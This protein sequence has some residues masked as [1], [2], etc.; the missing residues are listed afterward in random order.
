MTRI[1]VFSDMHGNFPALEAALDHARSLS[2]D[3]IVHAG[4]M[5][6]GPA[7]AEVLDFLA[8][9]DLP[10]V[11]GNHE[12][13][14]LQCTDPA[15]PDTLRSD[16]YAPVR[17]TRTTLTEAHLAEIAS[18]P[19]TMNPHPD[20][21]ILHGSTESLRARLAVETT[22]DELLRMYRS[23]RTPVIVSGHT[24]M[25]HLRRLNGT[26]FVNAG[27]TGRPVDGDR[28]GAYALLTHRNGTWE[29]EIVRV[30]YDTQPLLDAARKPGGWLECGGGLAAIMLH[31]MLDG[32]RWGKP[33]LQWWPVEAPSLNVHDAYRSYARMTGVMPLI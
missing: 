4:D 9:H 6:N 11:F 10:G 32:H 7:S 20:V 28:R 17:W 27:S 25:P 26:A 5:V 16:Q 24:H 18:W 21:T 31:E 14:V 2:A 13:Y 8:A 30:P 23:I 22:D 29:T 12:E 3:I 1:A 15:A 33:F 19:V